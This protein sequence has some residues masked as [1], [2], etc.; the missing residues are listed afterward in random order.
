MAGQSA[1]L[2]A[3]LP[4][5]ADVVTGLIVEARAALAKLGALT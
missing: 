4:S 2:V 1:G 5:A 3:D